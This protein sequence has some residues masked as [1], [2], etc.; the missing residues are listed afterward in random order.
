MTVPLPFDPNQT[1]DAELGQA[2][3]FM[4]EL[5]SAT[6]ENHDTPDQLRMR[7]VASN[8]SAVA[9][10]LLVADERPEIGINMKRVVLGILGTADWLVKTLPD[11]DKGEE[12][13]P[14]G[15]SN[16]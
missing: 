9:N 7:I 11:L 6:P 8:L 2:M 5:I 16:V 15:E 10:L 12:E 4:Y 14:K 13:T 3:D 1:L